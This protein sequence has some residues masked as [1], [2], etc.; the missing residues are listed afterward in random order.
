M[1]AEFLIVGGG[2]GG[3]VLAGLLGKADRRVLVL[4]RNP[5]KTPIVR[6]EVLWPVTVDIFSTLL[7]PDVLP[8]TMVAVKE[9]YVMRGAARLVEIT[10]QTLAASGVQPWSTDPGATRSKLLELGTFEVRLGVE[11]VSV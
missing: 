2:I 7:P 11:A 3:G 10:R 5:G 8:E 1:D 6:P 4:E 9:L